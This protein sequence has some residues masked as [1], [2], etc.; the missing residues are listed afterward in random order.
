MSKRD[1]LPPLTDCP[2]FEPR[3]ASLDK[4]DFGIGRFTISGPKALPVLEGLIRDAEL[5]SGTHEQQMFRA[6]YLRGQSAR[7]FIDT[8]SPG[9][10]R[11]AHIPVFRG[12]LKASLL[13]PSRINLEFSANLNVTRAVQAQKVMRRLD[14]PAIGRAPY[15]LLLKRGA[16]SVEG[17]V[18]LVDS[19]NVIIG[20]DLRYAYA[21]S[22]PASAHLTDLVIALEEAIAVPLV[23]AA[24]GHGVHADIETAYTL[25]GAEIYWEFSTPSPVSTVD[26]LSIRLPAAVDRSRTTATPISLAVSEVA[27][28]SRS[29]LLDLGR[30][31]WLRIY[32]KTNSR[33]RFEVLF[34]ADAITK[35]NGRR[36]LSD[37][38]AIAALIDDLVLTASQR[39]S[40]LFQEASP[41]LYAD[42]SNATTRDFLHAIDA[43]HQDRGI[44]SLVLDGLRYFGRVV[45]GGNPEVLKAAQRLK[46][47]NVLRIIRRQQSWYGV[48][49]RYEEALLGLVV[50]PK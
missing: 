34:G 4:V 46:R 26:L 17:E 27:Q 44:S 30:K 13:S 22:R 48:T 49:A 40:E 50:R 21:M 45:P 23:L 28:Q 47:L 16:S 20:S 35:A 1:Y 2:V 9:R 39:L 8:R 42:Q 33:V 32:A 38:P 7:F 6:A 43:A 41:P 29:I 11:D 24:Q 36:R 19:T 5:T 15:T 31:M 14:R 3:R 10:S 25:R 12:K 37:H 18:P